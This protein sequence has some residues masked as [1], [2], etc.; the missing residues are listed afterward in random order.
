MTSKRQKKK[1]YLLPDPI[2]GYEL[3]C[4]QLRI[5][6]APEY[7][8]AFVGAVTELTK[9]WNWEKS[10][11]KLDKRAA[12]AA[13]YWRDVL[14][15]QLVETGF[16]GDCNDCPPCPPECRIIPLDD[17]RID[18]QPNDPFRTPNLIPDG[19][20]APPWYIAPFLNIIG[21]AQGD[22][23][24]D[25]LRF[26]LIAGWHLQYQVPRFRLT[27]KG[28]G[29]IRLY[30]VNVLQGGL[31]VIQ[32]DGDLL[33]LQYMDLERD[34]TSNPPETTR[35]LVIELK[36]YGD[37]EHFIDVQMFPNVDDSLIPIRFGGGIE[38]IEMCGFENPCPEC[39]ECPDCPDPDC[40]N[41]SD[42]GDA[43]CD[44]CSDCNDCDECEE[45][46]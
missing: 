30:M 34:S 21:A 10:Y 35:E 26:P 29:R 40:E 7:K 37:T 4:V 17:P 14:D 6:N 27:V 12:R 45:C 20:Y 32:T 46:E 2:D 43:D 9:W 41:C 38:K 13:K 1:G 22:I 18:W 33:Q 15:P 5:P 11:E 8:R 23:V 28:A 36:V 39:P 42:C 19:Y 44:D 16:F 25:M 31:A 24:T 3:I